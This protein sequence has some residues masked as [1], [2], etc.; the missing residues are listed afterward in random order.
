MPELPEVETM[1][2]GVMEIVG[3]RIREVRQPRSDLKPIKITPRFGDFRRRAVGC[4][5]VAVDRLGKRVVVEL[6]SADRII[7]EPR[8]TGRLLLVDPPDT[9]HLRLIFD[10]S[11]RP[12]RR[13][14]FWNLRGL[15]VVHL[16]SP[17]RFAQQCGLD[18]IGP[19]ALAVSPEMLRERLQRSTRS[20][21]VALLDQRALAGIGNI[22]ASEILHR[23]GVHP[24]LPCNELRPAKWKK[25]R[26]AIV[27]VLEEA[28][29]HQGSTLS[30]GNYRNAR[31]EPGGFQDL[32]RVY[33]R[34]DEKCPTCRRG[35]IAK[36]VQAQRSTFFCPRCQKM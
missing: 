1:R 29:L 23:I 2:R 24:E 6:D 9:K 17:R 25:L 16:M 13:L 7:F 36:I 20:I 28:I 5:I 4:K 8:M 30:D 21:K 12:A 33:Q 14:L 15:G 26:A 18:K 31:N 32:H 19:D 22:Y 10:L 34:A 3:R 27:Q 35:T 11:G